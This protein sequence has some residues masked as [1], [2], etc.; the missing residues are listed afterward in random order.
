M[1]VVGVSACGPLTLSCAKNINKRY[2]RQKVVL[3]LN[4]FQCISLIISPQLMLF[5]TR[6]ITKE[7]LAMKLW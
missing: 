1:R 2:D 3:F 4:A 5:D 6:L 7:I